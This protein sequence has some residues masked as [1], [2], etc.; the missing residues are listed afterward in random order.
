MLG[1]L[2]GMGVVVAL[3]VIGF[4][5]GLKIDSEREYKTECM[6]FELIIPIDGRTSTRKA[7]VR[8]TSSMT[9]LAYSPRETCPGQ[10]NSWRTTGPQ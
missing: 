3:P 2:A 6:S 7:A 4:N 5:M 9:A 10:S 8:Q 1:A